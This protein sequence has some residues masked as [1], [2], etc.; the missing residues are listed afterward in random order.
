MTDKALDR[1]EFIGDTFGAALLAL[2]IVTETHA[3]QSPEVSPNAWIDLPAKTTLWGAVMFLSDALVEVSIGTAKSSESVRGRVD[4]KRLVEYS[5]QNESSKPERIAIRATV[6]AG[7]RSLPPSV[8]RFTAEQSCYLEFGDRSTP[9]N[10][11]DRMGGYPRD[12][13]VTGFILFGDV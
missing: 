7:N 2:P 8:V 13:V 10:R 6:L 5:W 9:V 1:R 12:V 11:A 4:G 3:L